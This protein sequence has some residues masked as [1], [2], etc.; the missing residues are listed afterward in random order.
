ML[1]M[2]ALLHLFDKL[3]PHE[4]RPARY[5]VVGLGSQVETFHQVVGSLRLG[6]LELAIEQGRPDQL[7]KLVPF[8]ITDPSEPNK[9]GVLGYF[10]KSSRELP[11]AKSCP[12]PGLLFRP[13]RSE[14]QT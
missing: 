11:I 7:A 6:V 10:I 9:W 12:N 2:R 3:W 14:V 8:E 5:S 4:F 13:A 1:P